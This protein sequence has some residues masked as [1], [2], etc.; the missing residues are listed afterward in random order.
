MDSKD[1]FAYDSKGLALLR[2]GNYAKSIECLNRAIVLNPEDSVPYNNKGFA[3]CKLDT[4][5]TP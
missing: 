1:S 2:Q 3:L 4:M 5:V